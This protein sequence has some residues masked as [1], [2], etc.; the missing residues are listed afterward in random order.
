MEKLRDTDVEKYQR[1]FKKII[2]F[3]GCRTCSKSL[4]GYYDS[5]MRLS[6]PL[7]SKHINDTSA[8]DTNCETQTISCPAYSWH[9]GICDGSCNSNICK[10]N[11]GDCSQ[12]CDLIFVIIIH[13]VMV[14]VIQNVIIWNVTLII[15]IVGILL[16]TILQ[17][18]KYI[19]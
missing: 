13:L 18:D 3:Q 19:K 12:S 10:Y 4:D 9:D 15:V 16:I 17:L 1:I 5:N 6:H 8:C 7:I 2:Y 11:D 14:Y